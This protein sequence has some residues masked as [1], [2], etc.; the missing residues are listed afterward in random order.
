[1]GGLLKVGN[2]IGKLGTIVE[3]PGIRITA[4]S[5]HGLLQK[6]GRG[7]SSQDLLNTVRNAKI[8]FSQANGTRFLFLS[9]KTAVVVDASGK[10]ITTY[11]RANF[12]GVVLDIINALK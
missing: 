1:V 10:V 9:D 11:G 3:N 7:V 2:T 12:T 6:I 8:V 5:V 4:Y